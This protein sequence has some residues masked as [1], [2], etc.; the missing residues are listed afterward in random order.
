MN[1]DEVINLLDSIKKLIE[2]GEYE[3]LKTMIEDV[4]QNILHPKDK[5]SEYVDKL[6]EELK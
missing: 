4:K 1:N 2:K 6:V 5:S 3:T